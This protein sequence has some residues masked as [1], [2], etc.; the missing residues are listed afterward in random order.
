MQRAVSHSESQQDGQSFNVWEKKES[1][2]QSQRGDV[3]FIDFVLRLSGSGKSRLQLTSTPNPLD[4]LSLASPS[5]PPQVR[6]PRHHSDP[7]LLP[8]MARD[9]RSGTC[10]RAPRPGPGRS[11]LRAEASYRRAPRLYQERVHA[12]E[13][14][15]MSGELRRERRLPEG[16]AQPLP[17]LRIAPYKRQYRVSS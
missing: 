12:L 4:S 3:Q 7:A 14:R 11:G 13:E 17:D 2:C 15:P 5:P 8:T 10:H 16:S 9:Q 6:E 1:K